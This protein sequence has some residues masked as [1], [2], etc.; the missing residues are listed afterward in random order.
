MR[1]AILSFFLTIFF[2]YESNA[3]RPEKFTL[4]C[5]LE[6]GFFISSFTNFD[7]K[8]KK[9]FKNKN[10][11]FKIDTIS[12]KISSSSK[13]LLILHGI[14]ESEDLLNYEEY[15]KYGLSKKKGDDRWEKFKRYNSMYEID[16]FW[17]SELIIEE[18]P[19]TKYKYK[20]VICLLCSDAKKLLEIK[21]FEYGNWNM[22]LIFD[23]KQI[24]KKKDYKTQKV[25]IPKNYKNPY[26]ITPSCKWNAVK[27]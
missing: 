2:T 19:L 24:P 27:E 9:K 17:I 26:I 3:Y 21:I 25:T 18:N 6:D 5:S 11:T 12:K 4:D 15:I 7:K 13:D 20:G 1:L 22:P 8:D 14:A 10:L 16:V 23:K